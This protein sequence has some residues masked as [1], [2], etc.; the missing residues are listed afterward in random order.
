[1]ASEISGLEPLRAFIKRENR[2]VRVWFRLM[3]KRKAQPEFVE[4]KM[5][6]ILP[7]PHKAEEISAN[8]KAV[9][10]PPDKQPTQSLPSVQAALPFDAPESKGKDVQNKKAGFLWDKSKGID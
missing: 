2:V 8:K 5:P 4:R 7:R 6:V 3:K 10:L 1:M 9:P